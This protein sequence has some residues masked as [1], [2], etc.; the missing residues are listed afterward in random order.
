MPAFEVAQPYIS[1]IFLIVARALSRFKVGWNRYAPKRHR[2]LLVL[3]FSS[4]S[5]NRMNPWPY[6]SSFW[7]TMKVKQYITVKV[8]VQEPREHHEGTKNLNK[9][10]PIINAFYPYKGKDSVLEGYVH[11]VER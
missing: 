3:I 7:S 1:L 11:T 4:L 5:M 10:T 9:M 8:V 6:G 2:F